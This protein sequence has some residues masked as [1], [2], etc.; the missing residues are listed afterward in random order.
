MLGKELLY[1]FGNLYVHSSAIDISVEN[2]VTALPRFGQSLTT[3]AIAVIVSLTCRFLQNG[4]KT[5]Y[6]TSFEFELSS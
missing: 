4:I 5:P 6:L 2:R 3:L 1:K